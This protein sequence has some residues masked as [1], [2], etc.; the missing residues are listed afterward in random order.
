MSFN[1]LSWE[2]VALTNSLQS[3]IN[4]YKERLEFEMKR[5]DTLAARNSELRKQL[6]Q[7]EQLRDLL[8]NVV[9]EV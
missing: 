3:Q 4:A 2:C 8:R 6:I 1:K 9:K 5:S 7:Y